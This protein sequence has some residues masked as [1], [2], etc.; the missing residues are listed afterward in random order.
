MPPPDLCCPSLPFPVLPH[1]WL[2]SSGLFQF[3][4][5]PR[6]G[7]LEPGDPSFCWRSATNNYGE[8]LSGPQFPIKTRRTEPRPLGYSV[9][10]Q[11][12]KCTRMV[13]V[14]ISGLW[15]CFP[16]FNFHIRQVKDALPYTKD[17]WQRPHRGKSPLGPQPCEAGWRRAQPAVGRRAKPLLTPPPEKGPPSAYPLTFMRRGDTGPRLLWDRGTARFRVSLHRKGIPWAS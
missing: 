8:P 10:G 12:R 11:R 5:T 3:I 9:K 1:S 13:T 4:Q 14:A 6:R 17:K 7:N 15:D 2:A 16:L